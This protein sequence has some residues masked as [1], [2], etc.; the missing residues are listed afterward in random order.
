MMMEPTSWASLAAA[1]CAAACPDS[2]LLAKSRTDKR[3]CRPSKSAVSLPTISLA[4]ARL[5]SLSW[6]SDEHLS[7]L[8]SAATPLILSPNLSRKLFSHSMA[9][10]R[11]HQEEKSV[12][13]FLGSVYSCQAHHGHAILLFSPIRILISRD[14]IFPSPL[15]RKQL[16][17]IHQFY[18]PRKLACSAVR[19]QHLKALAHHHTSVIIPSSPNCGATSIKF[20]TF[21]FGSRS[22]CSQIAMNA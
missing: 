4:V 22:N 15:H 17:N 7:L 11:S 9:Y 20:G 16:H 5:S 2:N 12:L 1:A 14:P 3:C 13:I 18:Y 10:L 21:A 8:T 19:H 6:P